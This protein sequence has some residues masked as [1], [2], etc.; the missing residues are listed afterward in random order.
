LFHCVLSHSFT[1]ACLPLLSIRVS[2]I[3]DQHA[4]DEKYRFETLQATT[5]LQSQPLLNPL[6]LECTPAMV[7]TLRA[8][9]HIFK[10]NGFDIDL[11]Q[12]DE[13]VQAAEAALDDHAASA[14]LD[15]SQAAS[16]SA[17]RSRVRVRTLPFSKNITF[18]AAD[19]YELCA[20]LSDNPGVMVRLPKVSSVQGWHGDRRGADAFPLICGCLF[21]L[22]RCFV[23]VT[24]M[25]ASRACRSSVMIG[26]ALSQQKMSSIVRHMA[27][28]EHPWACPH[29]SDEHI[30]RE[31]DEEDYSSTVPEAADSPVALLLPLFLTDDPP[32]AI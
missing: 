10:Q 18:G 12:E 26:T 6:P 24:S 25:F 13:G 31:I 30:D 22:L 2:F 9:L 3:I 23:Q 1:L 21:G 20:L 17:A 16:V 15:A 28:M 5:T 7:E 4:T 32:C 19:I 29:G 11:P 8:N 27:D 14:S